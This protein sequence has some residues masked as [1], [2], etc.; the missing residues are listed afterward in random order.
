M[1]NNEICTFLTSIHE[2]NIKLV[3]CEKI[4]GDSTKWNYKKHSHS[5]IEII[6]FK[7]GKLN[8]DSNGNRMQVVTYNLLFYPPGVAHQEYKNP[9]INQEVI[10]IGIDIGNVIFTPD[11]SFKLTDERGVFLFLFEQIW[12]E[13][14]H[15]SEAAE[16][17][18]HTYIKAIFLYSIRYFKK[19]PFLKSNLVSFVTEY[20]LNNYRKEI[21]TEKQASM[22][23]VSVSYLNRIFRRETGTTPIRYANQHRVT[24][25]KQLLVTT[26]MPVEEIAEH[27]GYENV[28]YFW[29]VFKKATDCSPSEY[30][31]M[32]EKKKEG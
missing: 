1:R 20:I 25:A 14:S 17:V 8:V 22:C 27:V 11:Y 23:M 28:N 6:F 19:Q 26:D 30:R 7:N 31:K 29:R 2:E 10:E 9:D 21:S 32:F 4:K 5:Y 13:Y 3:S 16:Q 15:N 12:W 24:I 18:I